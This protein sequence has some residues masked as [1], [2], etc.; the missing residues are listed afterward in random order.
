MA[1]TNIVQDKLE[2]VADTCE[3]LGGGGGGGGEIF[4]MYAFGV[5]LRYA[6]LS[7]IMLVRSN[8]LLDILL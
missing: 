2:P 6:N 3:I 5:G 4:N 8:S 1:Q 7:N